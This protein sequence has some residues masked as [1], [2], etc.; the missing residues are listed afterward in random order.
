MGCAWGFWGGRGG[1]AWGRADRWGR[2]RPAGVG[3]AATGDAAYLDHARTIANEGIASLWY[4]GLFRGQQAKP[5]YE[6][7][8]GVG[9]FMDGL[10]R[11][12]QA[13]IPE[14]GGAGRGC[15]GSEGWGCFSAAG[16]AAP[17][18]GTFSILFGTQLHPQVKR[19]RCDSGGGAG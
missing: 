6:A 18:K 10:V 4:E 8:D 12:D 2:V 13:A 1:L 9:L 5:Y 17:R 3:G 16:G 7:V 11:L 14:P 15:W 19:T